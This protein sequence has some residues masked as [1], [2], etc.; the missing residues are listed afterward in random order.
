MTLPLAGKCALVTGAGSGIGEATALLLA[1]RGARVALA[2]RTES[3][4]Q[5][6]AGEI[7]AGGGDCTVVAGDLRR[8]READVAVAAA[9]DWGGGTLWLLVNCAGIYRE[10]PFE[11]LTDE[12]IDDLVGC[13]LTGLVLV[14]RAAL[15]S[16]TPGSC[17]VNVASM[18]GVRSLD[19]QTL[20]AA[21]K[22]A[23]VH[24]SRSLAR[25][26]APRRIRV[27][28]MSPGP[29][30]TPILRTIVSEDQVPAIQAEL[31]RSIVP[32]GRLGEP[33][34]MAEAILFLATSEFATGTHLVLDGGTSL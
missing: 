16:M 4:L 14:T 12:T 23:V 3:K 5:R 6:V 30:R 26:L 1:A 29:A 27:N 13:N 25:E 9:A 17:V 10:G 22:A 19:C 21:T 7:G 8:P 32:L 24:L 33:A 31:E 2:G 15:R 18:S 20:Y 11:E 34:E 28:A